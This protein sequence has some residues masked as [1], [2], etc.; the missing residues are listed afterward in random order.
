MISQTSFHPA[1]HGKT[2]NSIVIFLIANHGFEPPFQILRHNKQVIRKFVVNCDIRFTHFLRTVNRNF[3]PDFRTDVSSFLVQFIVLFPICLFRC[4][5]F[6]AGIFN[7]I[8]VPF[9]S[10]QVRCTG[11][12]A[13]TSRLNTR[14][15]LVRRLSSFSVLFPV[16]AVLSFLGPSRAMRDALRVLVLS[17]RQAS[18]FSSIL[19]NLLNLF[20]SLLK[21]FSRFLIR[22]RIVFSSTCTR[23]G[24]STAIGRCISL[25]RLRIATS[26]LVLGLGL[27]L[28]ITV[29]LLR[30]RLVI[31]TALCL[32]GHTNTRPALT[33]FWAGALI[34]LWFFFKLFD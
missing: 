16:I 28:G 26:L 22:I 12:T 18:S 33:A 27:R 17:F 20:Q 14:I 31:A 21:P 7:R 5:V 4:R 3:G 15:T 2:G 9:C 1:S 13:F 24:I 25:L 30:L 11:R 8:D 34:L 32:T 6:L 29:S 10:R 23:I 19:C